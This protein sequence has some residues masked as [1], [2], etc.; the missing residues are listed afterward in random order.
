MG[1]RVRR[2]KKILPGLTLNMSEKGIG[3]SMGGPAGRVSVSPS[4]RVT[5]SQSIPGTGIYRS[6]V[7]SSGKAKRSPTAPGV[8]KQGGCGRWLLY[9]VIGLVALMACGLVSNLVSPR[10]APADPASRSSAAVPLPTW[11]ATPEAQPTEP[12]P[13]AVPVATEPPPTDMPAPTV[14][15]VT[16][17]AVP[18]A[19]ATAVEAPSGPVANSQANVREGPGTEYAVMVVAEPG[20][21]MVVT[22]KDSS[23]EWLQLGSGYW[24][25]AALVDNAPSDLP[26]TAVVAQ[27]PGGNPTPAQ[28]AAPAAT[29]S[30]QREENGIVFTSDCPCDQGDTLNCPSFGVDMDAQACYMRCMDLT[31]EDVHK[32][33]RDKDGSACEWSW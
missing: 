23:G 13:T 14:E 11:T 30:W 28:E 29:P 25:A 21:A 32:L 17:T 8:K 16:A 19:T 10:T 9:G 1:W 7:V 33:D 4:E 26:V 12:P 3:L 22:G 24:I 20:Q 18:A 15:P 5:F 2:R 31:G 27:L 6:Q